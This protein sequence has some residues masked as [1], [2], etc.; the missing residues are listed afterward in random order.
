MILLIQS[1]DDLIKFN[2]GFTQTAKMDRGGLYEI[3]YGFDG[4][5]AGD[6][7]TVEEADAAFPKYRDLA[8]TRAAADLGQ[9]YW[10]AL[11]IVRQAALTD[12]AYELGGRGLS[13]FLHMLAAIR[14]QVWETAADECLS[15]SY[16]EQVQARSG[17][18]AAMLRDGVW[19][20]V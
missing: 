13:G 18:A 6:E 2:E 19:P 8:I 9:E 10:G 7:M 5:R 1:V 11:D 12:M 17:R 16:G 3:G 20:V 4:A 14:A 15:S